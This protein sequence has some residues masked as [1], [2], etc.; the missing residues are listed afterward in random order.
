MIKEYIS[1]QGKETKFSR[2]QQVLS[3]NLQTPACVWLDEGWHPQMGGEQVDRGGVPTTSLLC[4]LSSR[5]PFFGSLALIFFLCLLSQLQPLFFLSLQQPPSGFCGLVKG[6]EGTHLL[7]L[8]FSF[9]FFP[10]FCGR[11]GERVVGNA[12]T[13]LCDLLSALPD[14]VHPLYLATYINIVLYIRKKSK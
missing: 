1:A 10:L 6:W 3:K 7:F 4:L 8:P 2:N 14:Q 12:Q 5:T 13:T 9:P 11:L